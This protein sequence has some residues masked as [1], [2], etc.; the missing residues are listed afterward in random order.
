MGVSMAT[1]EYWVERWERQQ[2]RYAIHREERFAVLA[3][4][5]EYATRDLARPLL[6]DLGC[7]PGS[8]AARLAGRLPAAEIVAVDRD[9]LLLELA[10]THR[11]DAARYVEAVLGADGW[12]EALRLDRAPDAVLTATALHCL[13]ERTLELTYRQLGELLRPGGM[14]VNADHFPADAAEVSGLAAHLG[15]RRMAAALE[16][17]TPDWAAWWR[18]AAL[19]P[20]LAHAFEERARRQPPEG[21]GGNALTFA[22]HARLLRAAGFRSVS[23][24]WQYGVSRVLVAFT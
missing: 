15:D 4:V 3:D 10:R 16:G 20:E 5:A 2:R 14:L 8:L 19:D 12:T 11:P 6:V 23:C 21:E 22:D 24:V 13:S 18:E 17:D 1:A 9:P 7:G